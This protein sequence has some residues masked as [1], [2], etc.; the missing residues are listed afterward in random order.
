VTPKVTLSNFAAGDWVVRAARLGCV[1]LEILQLSV[2][3]PNFAHFRG[4]IAAV[5]EQLDAQ[6]LIRHD[7]GVRH[8]PN[9][10]FGSPK[11]IE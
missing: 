10:Y 4:R 6:P 8:G 3:Q 5:F 11:K 1:A 7:A 2:V 9:S